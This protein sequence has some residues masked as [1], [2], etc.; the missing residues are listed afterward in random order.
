MHLWIQNMQHT[1][2]RV[3][4]N[5]PVT[6]ISGTVT[7]PNVRNGLYCA[8]WWNTYIVTNP[9][10]LTQTLTSSGALTLKLPAP[11]T[12]DVAVQVRR[13]SAASACK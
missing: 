5:E 12:D 2:T 3:V 1:W 11:L 6:P 4:A 10:F 7:I 9:I 8:T 13:V